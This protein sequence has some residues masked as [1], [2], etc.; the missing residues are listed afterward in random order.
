[1]KLT[2]SVLCFSVFKGDS[3]GPMVC[4]GGVAGV[5]SF[6]GRICGDPNV[7]NVYTRVSSFRDWITSVL[8]SN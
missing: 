2:H 4:D 8:N 3:G 5:V 1:M 7:P 6:G